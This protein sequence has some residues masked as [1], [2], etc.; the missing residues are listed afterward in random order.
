MSFKSLKEFGVSAERLGSIC[1]RWMARVQRSVCEIASP[2]LSRHVVFL[3]QCV[4]VF[5]QFVWRIFWSTLGPSLTLFLLSSTSRPI[6]I[7]F[8]CLVWVWVRQRGCSCRYTAGYWFSVPKARLKGKWHDLVFHS[9]PLLHYYSHHHSECFCRYVVG[10][11][12]IVNNLQSPA[13]L[14]LYTYV[15]MVAAEDLM[16]CKPFGP[17]VGLV[18]NGF[19]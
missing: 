16:L 7:R 10:R 15:E 13:P 11:S 1:K 5:M 6:R 9:S 19:S 18:W 3:S 14:V 8:V 2:P 4:C 17:L 12:I